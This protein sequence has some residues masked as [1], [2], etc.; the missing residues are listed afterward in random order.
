MEVTEDNRSMEIESLDSFLKAAETL[1]FD[2]FGR[3]RIFCRDLEESMTTFSF[4]SGL[5]GSSHLWSI[6]LASCLA[7]GDLAGANILLRRKASTWSGSGDE[8]AIFD[9]L[10]SATSLLLGDDL[11][12]AIRSIP[13]CHHDQSLNLV[14]SSLK[15]CLLESYLNSIALAYTRVTKAKLCSETSLAYDELLPYCTSL[16]WCEETDGSLRP[17]YLSNLTKHGDSIDTS[18]IDLLAQCVSQL[19]RRQPKVDVTM[20]KEKPGPRPEY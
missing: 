19:E 5:T 8:K 2:D 12:S 18:T 14:F 10:G 13:T 4:S 16:G 1:N 9:Q 11:S 7:L 6:Y 20:T 15:K 3:I 17:R